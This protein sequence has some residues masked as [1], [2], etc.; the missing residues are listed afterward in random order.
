MLHGARWRMFLVGCLLWVVDAA[1]VGAQEAPAKPKILIIGVD[2]C[3]PDALLAANTPHLDKLIATGAFADQAQCL[4]D[5]PTVGDSISGPGWSSILTGVWAE[6]HGVTDNR[7]ADKHYDQHPHF[8]QYVKQHNPEAITASVVSWRPIAEHIVSAAALNAKGRGDDDTTDQAVTL[9][10]EKDVDALFVHLDD[11]DH[12]GHASGY[13]PQSPEY[14]KAIEQAD[15]RIGRLIEAMHARPT[16]AKENWL[17]LVT[18]DHGG[19]DKGHGGGADDPLKRTVFVLVSGPAA[20]IGRMDQ[21]IYIVDVPVTALAH[22]GV[23]IKTDW[24]LDGRVVGLKKDSGASADQT[25][26]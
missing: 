11:V 24:C 21:P 25:E 2:G 10:T 12:A 9:L 20:E 8:F 23:S 7:F 16:F 4:P 18:T 3:R 19:R 22:L 13:G 17:I 6:K 26:K 14:V 1:A 5:R 15:Q